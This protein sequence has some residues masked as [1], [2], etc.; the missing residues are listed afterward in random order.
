[1]TEYQALAQLAVDLCMIGLSLVGVTMLA[2]AY[3]LWK[4]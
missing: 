3:S 1:M 4:N 2:A